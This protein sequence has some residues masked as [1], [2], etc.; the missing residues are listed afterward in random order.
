FLKRY[1]AT[2]KLIGNS[3]DE[4][5]LVLLT[6]VAVW[7]VDFTTN[8]FIFNTEIDGISEDRLKTYADFVFSRCVE[9]KL[10]APECG[11]LL[12]DNFNL[13][14]ANYTNITKK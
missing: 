10:T 5:A 6:D 11:L 12:S 13:Q 7:S 9:C 2:N 4:Y 14:P 1:V 3:S 8:A